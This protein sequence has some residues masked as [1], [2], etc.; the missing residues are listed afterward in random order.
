MAPRQ[1]CVSQ[2]FFMLISSMAPRHV[3][4]R[5]IFYML[6]SSAAPRHYCVLQHVHMRIWRL[7]MQYCISR[8]FSHVSIWRLASIAFRNMFH[9]LV[10]FSYIR[11][12]T[13]QALSPYAHKSV[14]AHCGD[15]PHL[16]FFLSSIASCFHVFFLSCFLSSI[17]SFF[18]FTATRH[19]SFFFV[20]LYGDAPHIY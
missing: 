9:M 6:T 8:N 7:A 14:Y 5:N 2:F 17:F 10:S 18:H 1:Y 12:A 15:A 11:A 3:A 19:I 20:P 4:S 16:L 13:R